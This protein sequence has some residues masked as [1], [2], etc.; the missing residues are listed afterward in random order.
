MRD[1]AFVLRSPQAARRI[2]AVWAGPHSRSAAL[3]G[4]SAFARTPSGSVGAPSSLS[5]SV[6]DGLGAPAVLA[7]DR[8]TPLWSSTTGGELAVHRG[9]DAIDLTT[10]SPG[11]PIA[12]ALGRDAAGELWLAWQSVGPPAGEAR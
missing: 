12:S 8:V 2:V 5:A 10:L 3:N 11:L 6:S 1:E 7:A 9:S 4:T